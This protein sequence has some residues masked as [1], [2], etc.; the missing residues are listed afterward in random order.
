MMYICI[1]HWWLHIFFHVLSNLY[2]YVQKTVWLLKQLSHPNIDFLQMAKRISSLKANS[3]Q[4]EPC[5]ANRA[6][7]L[8][9]TSRTLW[10]YSK[11]VLLCVHVSCCEIILPCLVT[12]SDYFLINP[13]FKSIICCR[14]W[15]ILTVS[16]GFMSSW[17]TPH[18]QC[19]FLEF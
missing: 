4:K 2:I 6:G 14:W 9:A 12:H 18:F 13:W 11:P 10:L 15:S 8:S 3:S 1:L 5:L 7:W 17:C 19:N 16:H